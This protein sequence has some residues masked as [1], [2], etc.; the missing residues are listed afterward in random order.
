MVPSGLLQVSG[1][2]LMLTFKE[3][4]LPRMVQGQSI[5]ILGQTYPHGGGH[6]APVNP[7][8]WRYVAFEL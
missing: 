5:M 3:K 1:G 6:A 7:T 4:D 8:W 2:I